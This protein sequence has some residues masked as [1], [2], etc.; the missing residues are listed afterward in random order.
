LRHRALIN[1]A[2]GF[3]S[4]EA[5]ILIGT[6]RFKPRC[7]SRTLTVTALSDSF[8]GFI[9]DKFYFIAEGPEAIVRQFVHGTRQTY[10]LQGVL[11]K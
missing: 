11:R 7:G 2:G 9:G 8:A 6:I 1:E 4:S 3:P 10:L 5:D